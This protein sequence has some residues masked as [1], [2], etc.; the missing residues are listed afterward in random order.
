MVE[1]NASVMR[2]RPRKDRLGSQPTQENEIANV[3]EISRKNVRGNENIKSVQLEDPM[4]P[5]SKKKRK[6]I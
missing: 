3:L 6:K 5:N 4:P 2:K 1:V